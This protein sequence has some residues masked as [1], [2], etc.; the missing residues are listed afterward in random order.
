ML[1]FGIVTVSP[2]LRHTDVTPTGAEL[3]EL[4]NRIP[5]PPKARDCRKVSVKS[6][7]GPS[8]NSHR[9]GT[10]LAQLPQKVALRKSLHNL[11][12]G[13]TLTRAYSVS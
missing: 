11:G 10:F 4:T 5:P 6:R 1:M 2:T 3:H 12:K 8:R 9:V 13:N 7:D